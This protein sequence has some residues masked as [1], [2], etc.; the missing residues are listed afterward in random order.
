MI[1]RQ[2]WERVAALLDEALELPPPERADFLDRACAGAAEL[3]AEV[4]ALLAADERAASFLAGPA[5]PSGHLLAAAVNERREEAAAERVGQRLG[6]YRLVRE[7]GRGGMGTVYLAERADGQFEQRVA[8]KLIRSGQPGDRVLRD[9]LRER[10][11][12]ARLEHPHV[13]RLLDGGLTPAGEPYFVMEH[14][15]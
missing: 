2:T 12:L 8:I 14:V 9:F 6:A 4:E 13:A 5:D 10:Q 3:R 1:D 7:I 11:I 15:A